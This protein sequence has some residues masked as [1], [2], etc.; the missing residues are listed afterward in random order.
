MLRVSS[1]KKTRRRLG[2]KFRPWRSALQTL[3]L[4][5]QHGSEVGPISIACKLMLKLPRVEDD[6]SQLAL[7]TR[8]VKTS[9]NNLSIS[10]RI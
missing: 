5:A 9:N 6:R 2:H 3:A 7:G 8:T 4:P 10:R 1:I